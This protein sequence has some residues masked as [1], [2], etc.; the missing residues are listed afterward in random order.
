VDTLPEVLSVQAAV[1]VDSAWVLLDSR[2][3]RVAVVSDDPEKTIVRFGREGDGPGEL[4]TPSFL[5]VSYGQVGVLEARGDRL[6]RFDLSGRVLG[7]VG[8]TD[9]GCAFGPGQALLGH[10]SGGFV[11]VRS[12]TGM[13]GGMRGLYQHVG[14]EGDVDLLLDLPLQSGN[15]F[16]PFRVPVVAVVGEKLLAGTLSEGCLWPLDAP[17]G[18]GDADALCM[19]SDERLPLPDSIRIRLEALAVQTSRVGRRLEMPDFLPT[20]IE[21][22]PS[23]VGPLLRVP[24]P[25]GR[26]ALDLLDPGGERTRIDAPAPDAV[27][28]GSDE[29]L[30]V[31]DL[32]EGTELA[33]IRRDG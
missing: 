13:D 15:R 29:I 31:R 24:L 30:L 2:A 4:Q 26:E 1:D 19:P 25:N 33:R 22:R 5:A 32:P 3:G 21:V 17:S 8:L 20:F 27:F 28:V 23:A 11:V 10:P 14:V 16:D 6:V 12:C 9:V 18:R 7:P